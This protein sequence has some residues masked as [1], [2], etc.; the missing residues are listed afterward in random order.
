MSVFEVR[1]LRLLCIHTAITVY[2]RADQGIMAAR[3]GPY[4]SA[5][6]PLSQEEK[7][8]RGWSS[9]KN[10]TKRAQY[11]S[12]MLGHE[13]LKTGKG[14]GQETQ[15]PLSGLSHRMGADS[16]HALAIAW[17]APYP[18]SRKVSPANAQRHRHGHPNAAMAYDS[19]L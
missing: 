9:D 10:F 8:E 2:S 5:I 15:Q 7:T 1:D 3:R 12:G 16:H 19:T 17:S 4:H 11:F 13:V 18:A 14:I 6:R